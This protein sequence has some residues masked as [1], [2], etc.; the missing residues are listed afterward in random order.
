MDTVARNTFSK[1]TFNDVRPSSIKWRVNKTGDKFAITWTKPDISLHWSFV[2][3]YTEC[4]ET[5]EKTF[6]GVDS[7]ELDLVPHCPYC[8]AIQAQS[9]HGATPWTK[10]KCFDADTDPNAWKWAAIIIPLMLAGVAALMFVC[11]RRNKEYIFPKV[12]QPRDLL[13][14]I[15]DNN[16]NEHSCRPVRPDSGRRKL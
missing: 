8:M 5:K 11:Y 10:E 12:P 6:Q 3:K 1:E 15:S 4:K 7:A 13:S 14:D 9:S 16:T 2:I